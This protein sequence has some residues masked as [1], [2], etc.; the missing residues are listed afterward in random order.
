MIR[1]YLAGPINGCTE[2]EAKNWRKWVDERFLV[3]VVGI[4]PLRCEPLIG[5]RY[6]MFY[7][8]PRFGTPNAIMSKNFIDVQRCDAVFAFLPREMNERRPSYGTVMEIGWATA[9]RKPVVLVSDDPNVMNHPVIS[10]AVQWKLGTLEEGIEVINGV[11][12][13]YIDG[14]HLQR[15]LRT[16][17]TQGEQSQ[18][19]SWVEK[20][21]ASVGPANIVDRL[22]GSNEAGSEEVRVVQLAG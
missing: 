16:G 3:G 13:H 21:I 5:E 9:L 15:K 1:I 14:K 17:S 19:P 22:S 2:G 8:D 10:H 18:R 7:E 4:S 20:T 12:S 11:F 6:G